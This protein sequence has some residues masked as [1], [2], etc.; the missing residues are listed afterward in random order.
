MHGWKERV[1][2]LRYKSEQQIINSLSLLNIYQ[3]LEKCVDK[4]DDRPVTV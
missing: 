3:S 4:L 1:D 2:I